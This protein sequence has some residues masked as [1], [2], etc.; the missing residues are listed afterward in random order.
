MK[1]LRL[2]IENFMCHEKSYIDFTQFSSAL[3]VGK[4]ENNDNYSNG[5]G[6]TT[7]FKA[8]EYVLFNQA[9]VNME[10]IIRDD[11]TSCRI[12]LD[13]LIGDQEYRVSRTRTRKSTDLSLFQRNSVDGLETEV[14]HTIAGD[15]YE[16]FA[17]KK[18]M[19]TYWKDLS[20]SRAGDTE[21]DLGKLIKINPKSFR[22]TIHFLQNDFGG[23]PTATPETRKKILKEAL[24]LAVYTK[25]EKIAK[26]RAAALG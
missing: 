11:T 19:E 21:K 1:P 16:P 13:F 7:I 24:N 23:L 4:M 18:V 6:K 8:I 9:D 3:I 14:Y 17:D 10:K 15:V 22:S 25:L 5:V 2:Y 26:D 20:G 12:V